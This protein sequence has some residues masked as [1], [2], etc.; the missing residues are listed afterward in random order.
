[1]RN[2]IF[3]FCRTLVVSL[4][5]L[6]SSTLSIVSRKHQSSAHNKDA[7][8]D[9]K[10]VSLSGITIG[11]LTVIIVIGILL[12]RQSALGLTASGRAMIIRT[13][14]RPF[15]RK[16]E[17]VTRTSAVFVR[18]SSTSTDSS[19]TTRTMADALLPFLLRDSRTSSDRRYPPIRLYIA[20]AGGGGTAISTLASTPGA[21]NVFLEG[22]I[23]YDQ[24]SFLRFVTTPRRQQ[25]LTSTT[26]T[27]SF[28]SKEAAIS[29]A[30]SALYSC[31][32]LTPHIAQRTSCV[33]I[34]CTSVLVSN[35]PR[36]G[37]HRCYVALAT[38]TYGE[39]YKLYSCTLTKNPIVIDPAH[40]NTATT[41]P[42]TRIE[43]EDIVSSIV[44][45]ALLK[46][47]KHNC[48]ANDTRVLQLDHA[49][50]MLHDNTTLIDNEDTFV[51]EEVESIPHD[52]KIGTP[53]ENAVQDIIRSTVLKP[54]HDKHIL[55]PLTTTS[56]LLVPQWIQGEVRTLVPMAPPTLLP[57]GT[58]IV[59]PGS[60]NP[61]HEGHMK[62]ARAAVHICQQR[63]LADNSEVMDDKPPVIFE[64]SISNADKP[65][66][67]Q[68]EV[69]R[70]VNLF[71][72]SSHLDMPDD[73]AVLL[74]ASPLFTHKVALVNRM[75]IQD[76][77][78]SRLVFVIGTDTL[79]RLLNPKYYDNNDSTMLAAIRDMKLKG[80]HF[81]VGGRLEQIQQS[82]VFISGKEQV[83]SMPEDIQNMFTLL[84]EE[85]FRMDISSTEIRNKQKQRLD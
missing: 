46:H 60:F 27:L 42:R 6:S 11:S 17:D 82:K 49:L 14:G 80:V 69:I 32:D 43:E 67:E 53:I 38:S 52:Q 7:S 10:T 28:C 41:R 9:W 39:P 37:H 26:A 33:G 35:T 58:V 12:F 65:V 59:F 13:R 22:R 34:G 79:V 20:V 84:S 47:V 55:S 36:K 2:F 8:I 45:Y 76:Y 4:H 3:N 75:V 85:E 73:W 64:M 23:L 83:Q 19:C 56:I 21:S 71:S 48:N 63:Q 57:G 78:H 62:L 15:L 66:M 29:L 31:L 25:Q 44:L 40:V 24:L 51:V 61:P 81:I 50:S 18:R 72:S 74:T 70:R 30:K 77:R 68:M 54:H 16:S 5:D 1:M